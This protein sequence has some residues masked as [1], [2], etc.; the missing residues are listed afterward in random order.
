MC[1]FVMI[2]WALLVVEMPLI[3][4]VLNS[5]FLVP[6]P[7]NG[8]RSV[9]IVGAAVLAGIVAWAS[10]RMFRAEKEAVKSAKLVHTPPIVICTF[11]LVVAAGVIGLIA[12]AR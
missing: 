4:V 7:Y 12:L 9:I 6:G 8:S 3:W 2:R 1:M 5:L 10:G 11:V